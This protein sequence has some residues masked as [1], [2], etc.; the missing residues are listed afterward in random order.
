MEVATRPKGGGFEPKCRARGELDEALIHWSFRRR[1]WG[2]EA[3][4]V[5]AWATGETGGERKR[6]RRSRG[7]PLA[8]QWVFYECLTS[9]CERKGVVGLAPADG[10][11]KKPG[12]VTRP[13]AECKSGVI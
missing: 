5:Y 4:L 12:V 8:A 13:M 2:R 6:P 1:S 11:M 9:T 10:V 3:G 7:C